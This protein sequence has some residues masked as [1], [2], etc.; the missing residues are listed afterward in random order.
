MP[1]NNGKSHKAFEENVREEIAAGKPQ[2]QAVA[3]AYS[4]KRRSGSAGK[5]KRGP[6]RGPGWID[7]A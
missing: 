7:S 4:E 1:L 3:I 5:K 6:K 2:D